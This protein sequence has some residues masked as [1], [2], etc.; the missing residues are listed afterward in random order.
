MGEFSR[1]DEIE[2]D[3]AADGADRLDFRVLTP[4][5]QA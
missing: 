1:G 5:P 3:V 4:T 2:V